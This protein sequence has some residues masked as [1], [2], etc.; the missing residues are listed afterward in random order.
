[1]APETHPESLEIHRPR[2]P[3]S[4]RPS[5]GAFRG[6]TR[7]EADGAF[8][9]RQYLCFSGRT[10]LPRT[11]TRHAC[12]LV[13]GLTLAACSHGKP[14]A[15]PPP[16]PPAAPPAP[17]PP[18]PP[19]PKCESLTENCTATESSALPIGALGSNIKP[20][21]GWK[22]AKAADRSVALS[23]EGKSLLTAV[24]ITSA[25]DGA[26]VDS[27]EK[28][29]I[30]SAIEKVK[31]EALKKRLKKPQIK[32]EA[33]GV[34]VELWEISKS[35]ANGVSPELREQGLGTV[36]VFVQK[37]APTRVITG[38]GFVVVPEAEAD[39]EKVM[40]AVQTLKGTP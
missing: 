33:N 2:I 23:S 22:Y 32:L 31:I 26:I 10:L 20:P 21:V 8:G 5:L 14:A 24:E 1:M 11:K 40:Q 18:P 30:A 27:I 28:L 15:A 16:P 36:L 12:S 25:E 17:P 34:P 29:L 38:L 9:N 39:A 6:K 7:P 3:K 19:P 13:L 4:W 37:L 35:T